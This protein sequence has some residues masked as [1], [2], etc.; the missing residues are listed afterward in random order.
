MSFFVFAFAEVDK[1]AG[2]LRIN[3]DKFDYLAM[4]HEGRH[5]TQLK[6]NGKRGLDTNKMSDKTSLVNK[7]ME[8]GAYE[9]EHSIVTKY[10]GDNVSRDRLRRNLEVANSYWKR[11]WQTKEILSS[12]YRNKIGQWFI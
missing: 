12:T 3:P 2:V 10:G 11:S 7:Y 4:R 5:F 6:I 9:F 8:H 1:G